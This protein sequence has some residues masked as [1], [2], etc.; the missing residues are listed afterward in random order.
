[1][2]YY[3]CGAIENGELNFL[4]H[5]DV[6]NNIALC[7]EVG[8]KPEIAIQETAEKTVEEY[9]RL[10]KAIRIKGLELATKGKKDP[11]IASCMNCSRY[12]L[13]SKPHI[14]TI[15]NIKI[16]CKIRWIN[17]SMYPAPCQ[18]NCIYC[19]VKNYRRLMH[20]DKDAYSKYYKKIEQIVEIMEKREIISTDAKWII[21][22]G[23]IAIHPFKE[24]L[25]QITKDKKVT[26]CTNC[27]VYDEQLARILQTNVYA[28]LSFS[29][30]SGT[31]ETWRK[32]KGANNFNTV[33]SNLF[34]Y[35]LQVSSPE[36][37]DLKYIVLPG[38]NDTVR[39]Y[40]GVIDIIKRCGINGITIS[41]NQYE[42]ASEKLLIAC[43]NF[44]KELV[45][46]QL[47]YKLIFYTKKEEEE[48]ESRLRES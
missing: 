32:I 7:C 24:Q 19:N 42:E 3:T 47:N 4:G 10:Y 27:F 22:S 35:S 8:T 38:V 44:I 16:D 12:V 20:L 45:N 36:Q 37:L 41:K 1:M 29:I 15:E 33:V 9:L 6:G 30:D 13:K 17:F 43:V 46:N 21:A 26:I 25:Y 28:S 11:L 39:D 48:I 5:V 23:E 31:E 2:K 18:A 14:K 34:R 40:K